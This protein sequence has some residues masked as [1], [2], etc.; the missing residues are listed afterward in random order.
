MNTGHGH[1]RS[2]F[3]SLFF[4]PFPCF[5]L[6]FVRCPKIALATRSAAAEES[7][8]EVSHHAL[9]LTPDTDLTTAVPNFPRL[10]FLSS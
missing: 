9:A 5:F 10:L 3:S 7:C 4:F 6:L 8:C 1:G 2:L